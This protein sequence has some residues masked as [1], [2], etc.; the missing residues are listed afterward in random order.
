MIFPTTMK[1]DYPAHYL[2]IFQVGPTFFQ[3]GPS[4]IIAVNPRVLEIIGVLPRTCSA[5]VAGQV[6]KL[7]PALL[8]L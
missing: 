6:D 4:M 2:E 3:V 7:V 5:T 1:M 8:G